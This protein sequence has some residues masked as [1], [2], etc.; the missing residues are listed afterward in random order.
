MN[1]ELLSCPKC[2]STDVSKPEFSRRVFAISFLLLGFPIPFL[3][4]TRHCFDCG[5]DFS[6]KKPNL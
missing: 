4:K 3:R 5:N 6:T 1:K 2:G